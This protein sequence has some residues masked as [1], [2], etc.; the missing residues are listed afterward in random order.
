[1]SIPPGDL[2]LQFG[3]LL[4]KIGHLLLQASGNPFTGYENRQA[5]I[6]L[7][8][9]NSKN[10]KENEKER[11]RECGG[12]KKKQFSFHNCLHNHSL[13]SADKHEGGRREREFDFQLEAVMAN[14]REIVIE[15]IRKE[16]E[17]KVEEGKQKGKAKEGKKKDEDKYNEYAQLEKKSEILRQIKEAENKT[18][19]VAL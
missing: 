2:S 6:P 10:K 19:E 3:H 13:P 17:G 1:M 5:L 4:L 9:M 12:R 11:G 15:N 8:R 14:W 18:S 16:S 7:L